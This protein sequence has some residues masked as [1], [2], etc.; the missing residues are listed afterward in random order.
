[1]WRNLI[2]WLLLILCTA[3]L[4]FGFSGEAASLDP[5]SGPAPEPTSVPPEQSVPVEEQKEEMKS[6]LIEHQSEMEELVSVM[7]E[8]SVYSSENE[9]TVFSYDLRFRELRQYHAV[10]EKRNIGYDEVFRSVDKLSEHPII[11]KSRFLDEKL[12]F[13]WVFTDFSHRMVDND[14]CAFSTCVLTG[15]GVMVNL[16]YCEE[17]PVVYWYN[18]AYYGDIEPVLPHW[19]LYAEEY[20]G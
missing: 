18:S 8:Y 1:M 14:I 16:F 6:F 10:R 20:G 7:M 17:D 15:E 13:E 4:F 19:Y 12:L 5:T 9:Y 11:T 3:R 2:L